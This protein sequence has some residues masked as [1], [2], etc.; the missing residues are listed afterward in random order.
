MNDV[1]EVGYALLVLCHLTNGHDEPLKGVTCQ[2]ERVFFLRVESEASRQAL[3]R[4]PSR[5]DLGY[6]L[7]RDRVASSDGRRVIVKRE[8]LEAMHSHTT[9]QPQYVLTVRLIASLC[10]LDEF[11]YVLENGRLKLYMTLY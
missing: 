3:P 6:G 10:V 4:L 9:V 11:Q 2:F 8:V 7:Q 1:L 5:F